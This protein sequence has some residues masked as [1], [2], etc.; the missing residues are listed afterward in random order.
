MILERDS[1]YLENIGE[2]LPFFF[3]NWLWLV[4]EGFQLMEICPASCFPVS[5]IGIISLPKVNIAPENRS[6]QKEIHFPAIDFQGLLPLVSGR[7]DFSLFAALRS[8]YNKILKG[9]VVIL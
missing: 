4:F 5:S 2:S 3:G 7:V 1:S 6:S 9:G 8:L